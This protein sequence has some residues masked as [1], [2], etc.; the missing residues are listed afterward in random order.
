MRA[1]PENAVWDRV[2]TMSTNHQLAAVF[3]VALLALLFANPA[4]SQ[5][6]TDDEATLT[7]DC[8]DGDQNACA[9][10]EILQA[11]KQGPAAV[12]G[13]SRGLLFDVYKISSV[14]PTE[15]DA[16][17]SANHSRFDSRFFTCL[18]GVKSRAPA[19]AKIGDEQCMVHIDWAARNECMKANAWKG[20]DRY[21]DDLERTITSNG[22]ISWLQTRSGQ[23]RAAITQIFDNLVQQYRQDNYPGLI[24]AMGQ[25]TAD[26]ML[27][28]YAGRLYA[29]LDKTVEPL[30][31][32]LYCR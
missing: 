29:G 27:A 14:R 30:R 22:A 10:L 9:E 13:D 24:F 25:E 21:L 16:F 19:L 31:D 28:D 1:R 8:F 15:L 26:Q 6:V 18:N 23:E 5:D 4:K 2:R 7:L 11:D 17:V 3:F 32:A 20:M 12:I